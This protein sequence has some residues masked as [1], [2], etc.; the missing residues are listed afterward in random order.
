MPSSLLES[1]YFQI[2]LQVQPNERDAPAG[3][4]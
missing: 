4:S 2:E 3:L 1:E